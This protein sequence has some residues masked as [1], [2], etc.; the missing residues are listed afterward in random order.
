MLSLERVVLTGVH[1]LIKLIFQLLTKPGIALHGVKRPYG[2][3]R[4]IPPLF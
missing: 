2:L 3:S 4:L 1:A